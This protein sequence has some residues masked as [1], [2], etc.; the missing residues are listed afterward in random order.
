MHEVAVS[1][2][3]RKSTAQRDLTADLGLL[4]VSARLVL[5]LLTEEENLLVS[6]HQGD[7]WIEVD[8]TQSFWIA[9]SL[10]MNRRCIIM[11]MRIKECL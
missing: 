10:S 1:A 3:C 9:L 7:S 2:G 4:R 5:R 6:A 8:Q 11:N